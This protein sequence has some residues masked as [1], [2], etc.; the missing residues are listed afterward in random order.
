M[1]ERWPGPINLRIIV[2]KRQLPLGLEHRD[3]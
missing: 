3:V 1:F 2:M